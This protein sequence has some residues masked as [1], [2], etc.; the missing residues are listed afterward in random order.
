MHVT[1]INEREAKNFKKGSEALEGG[2]GSG[3]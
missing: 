1:I 2:T 3:K